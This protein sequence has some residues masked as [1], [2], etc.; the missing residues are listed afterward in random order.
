MTLEQGCPRRIGGSAERLPRI[1][2][3]LPPRV[4]ST[5]LSERSDS[6]SRLLLDVA[7]DA[8]RA[9]AA[10]PTL[11]TTSI[12]LVIH[13][14]IN[15]TI[16]IGDEAGGDTV[17]DIVNK[18]LAKSAFVR[19]PAAAAAGSAAADCDTHNIVPTHWW[20]G[21]P[22]LEES[23]ADNAPNS[24]QEASPPA[25]LYTGWEWPD[26]CCPYYRT[27]YKKR[28]TS[29]VRHHGAPYLPL[30]RRIC[31]KLSA[32]HTTSD[33]ILPAFFR[34][35]VELTARNVPH[36]VVLR[37]FGSDLE[38]VAAAVSNFAAGRHPDH[39]HFANPNY[40]LQPSNLYR[41]RWIRKRRSSENTEATINSD[42]TTGD[43]TKDEF[44]Y[45]LSEYAP[46][47]DGS[48]TVADG[49]TQVLDRLHSCTICG[50]QDD[51]EFW[52][53]HDCQPWAGKPV[54][55]V[56]PPP[57]S[58]SQ[59]QTCY[60]HHVLFDDNI[61]NLEFDSIASLRAPV[62][63]GAS[64]ADSLSASQAYRTLTGEEILREQG[65]HLIRVPTIEPVLNEH[66]F[67]EQ[68]DRLFE[69]LGPSSPRTS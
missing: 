51:Y 27:A 65:I 14:D 32:A 62:P 31:E 29:F 21:S 56:L 16:L 69:K 7:S 12:H 39:P 35:L 5:A 60:Y 36:T 40:V 2:S 15:E 18:M 30:Y 25:P 44:V 34:T 1:L 3:F 46:Q 19:I 38:R 57:Q 20:D 11:S 52:S 10:S 68:I 6:S 4:P 48:S 54:W 13:F 42:A 49:D 43:E 9:R 58:Q 53:A 45:Q 28:S 23:G 50:I 67:V 26:Q 55:K 24:S 47:E 64:V 61:H 59:S 37:T 8:P 63:W 22:I 33:H 66:W 41:G 17:D